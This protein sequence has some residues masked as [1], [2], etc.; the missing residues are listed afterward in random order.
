MAALAI[1]VKKMSKVKMKTQAIKLWVVFLSLC[2][3][4]SIEFSAN[5]IDEIY[6][7]TIAQPLKSAMY[8]ALCVS[9]FFLYG[10]TYSKRILLLSLVAGLYGFLLLITLNGTYY[11]YLNG[12]I[13]HNSIN[14]DLFY[15][16]VELLIVGSVIKDARIVD[17]FRNTS[18]YS[19]V[20]SHVYGDKNSFT[21]VF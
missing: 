11:T 6:H 19:R 1:R 20:R 16:A 8:S 17:W 2:V 13:W 9:L 10:K 18:F 21:E 5:F 14:F 4:F 15:R 3:G 7:W 12:F